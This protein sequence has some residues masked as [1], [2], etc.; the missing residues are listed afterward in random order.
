MSAQP[1]RTYLA[2]PAH[3]RNMVEGAARSAADAVFLDLEDAVPPG[4]KAAA[5]AGA[6]AALA[7]LDWGQKH[8][9]VRIN[10]GAAAE[11]AALAGCARLDAIILPK[12]E[13]PRQLAEVVSALAADGGRIGLEA[14]IETAAGLVQVDSIAASGGRLKALHFG[15]GDF[16][17][18]LGA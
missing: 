2:V 7:E 10:A 14:L 8:V 11:A 12:T 5:L 3:R 6:K 18:S 17:A 4:E 15:V 9:S 1:R 16:A 13:H